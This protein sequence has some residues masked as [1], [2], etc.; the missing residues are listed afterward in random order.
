[1]IVGRILSA[2][3]LGF[4]LSFSVATTGNAEGILD[5]RVFTGMIGP[6]ENPDLSDSLYFDN[7]HFWSDICTRCGFVPGTYEAEATTDGVRFKGILE[8]ESRGQFGYDGLVKSDGTIR[9]SITWERR[10]WYWTTN[11]EIVFIG[12]ISTAPES[13]SLTETRQTMLSSEPDKNPMCARF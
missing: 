2:L 12:Q 4:V 10:R 9:V 1:M 5:G 13:A 7:G 8:S 11:R 6:A 3:A